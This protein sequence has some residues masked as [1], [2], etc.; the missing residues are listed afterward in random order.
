MCTAPPAL[1]GYAHVLAYPKVLAWFMP[2][3]VSA[4][5]CQLMYG[6]GELRDALSLV[7][8]VVCWRFASRRNNKM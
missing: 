3:V 8:D 4:M 7:F 1:P 5:T 6:I 2:S